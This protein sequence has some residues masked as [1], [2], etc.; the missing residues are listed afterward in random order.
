L[1]DAR[2]SLTMFLIKFD[3][4]VLVSKSDQPSSQ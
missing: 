1:P 4:D 2:S 3:D